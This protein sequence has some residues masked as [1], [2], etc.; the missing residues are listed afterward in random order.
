[1]DLLARR[2]L[3]DRVRHVVVVG[4]DLPLREHELDPNTP[5]FGEGLGLDSVDAVDLAVAV[6]KAFGQPIPGGLQGAMAL[7]SVNALADW[8]DAS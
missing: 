4:L 2:A 1:M 5:L 6:E 3:V 8:L 7:R